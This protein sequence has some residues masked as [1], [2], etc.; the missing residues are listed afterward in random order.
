MK[1]NLTFGFS[2]IVIFTLFFVAK[3]FAQLSEGGIPTGFKF[4]PDSRLTP[5]FMPAINT[6]SLLQDDAVNE[7]YKGRPYRFGY[8]HFVNYDYNNSGVWTVPTQW[9]LFMAIRY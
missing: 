9:R 6:D 3:S 7:Q 2:L 4:A 1:N 5:V 8:N